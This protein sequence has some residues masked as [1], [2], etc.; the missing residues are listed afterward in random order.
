[1][2]GRFIPQGFSVVVA[3]LLAG[4]AYA[5][6][7]SGGSLTFLFLSQAIFMA[8]P[9]AITVIAGGAVFQ[10]SNV[11]L[12]LLLC[13]ALW[14]NLLINSGAYPGET[15]SLAFAVLH[16]SGITASLF[17]L[18]WIATN[19]HPERVIKATGLLLAPLIVLSMV[20]ALSDGQ[21]LR[22]EPFGIHPNWWGELAMGYVACALPLRNRAVGA[23]MMCLG[24]ALLLLMQSRSGLLGTIVCIAT[25]SWLKRRGTLSWKS[26][27][28][29]V[30]AAACVLGVTALISPTTL[31]S[32]SVRVRAAAHAEPKRCVDP[33]LSC[34]LSVVSPSKSSDQMAGGIHW[35]FWAT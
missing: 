35:V 22:P 34:A 13:I 19:L 12:W 31:V 30:V 4:T 7:L 1:M 28:V 15:N 25:Y 32:V 5:F 9:F 26:H 3:T 17:C 27:L 6:V 33:F 2:N 24:F 16:V 29:W 18:Q 21:V 10:Q 14:T 11:L 20:V 23:V 8:A